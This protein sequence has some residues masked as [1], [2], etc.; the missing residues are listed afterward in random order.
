M[1]LRDRSYPHPVVGN[2]DDVPG[3]DFQV[4]I[5]VVTDPESVIIDFTIL[6]SSVTLADLIKNGSARYAAHIECSATSFRKLVEFDCDRHRTVLSSDDLKGH[7]EVNCFVVATKLISNYLVAGQHPDYGKFTFEIKPFDILARCDG[8]QFPID[9]DYS[10]FE[11]I[12]SI[13]VIISSPDVGDRP[14]Y[15][16]LADDKIQVILSQ[17]DFAAYQQLRLSPVA[18]VLEASVVLPALMTAVASLSTEE[19]DEYR[20]QR[21]LS[22]RMQRLGLSPGDDALTTAQ[23]L[24]DLPLRRALTLAAQLEDNAV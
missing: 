6:N 15:C 13:L 5:E 14:M 2:K 23:R 4:T 3:A 21:I 24:L 20:W 16:E 17:K 11:Q 9:H 19:P 12:G 10:G 22:A 18:R 8:F 1:K 7:V